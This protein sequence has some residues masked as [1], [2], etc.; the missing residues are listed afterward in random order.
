MPTFWHDIMVT[1]SKGRIMEKTDI[2]AKLTAVPKDSRGPRLICVHPKE[3][4]WIQQGQRLKLEAAITSSNLTK[5]RINFTDQTVNGGLA[6]ESS[7]S[8]RLATLDLKE[9]SDRISCNSCVTY[10]VTTCIT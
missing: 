9:A 8:G 10:L 2:V 4:I 6:L 3:A 1:E 5:G 7:K